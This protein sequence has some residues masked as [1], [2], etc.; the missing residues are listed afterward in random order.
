MVPDRVEAE[1]ALPTIRKLC[2]IVHGE[3]RP[4]R[5]L[6][7]AAFNE[8]VLVFVAGRD[9]I[10]HFEETPLSRDISVLTR[11]YPAHFHRA[12]P[13]T[14][15]ELPDEERLKQHRQFV[16][17]ILELENTGDERFAGLRKALEQSASWSRGQELP[18][19][20][21]PLSGLDDRLMELGGM[22]RY[23]ECVSA[24]LPELRREIEERV[25]KEDKFLRDTVGMS[26]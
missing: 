11:F 20:R 10:P 12:A 7:A 17:S 21:C 15:P 25:E 23:Y 19:R 18:H 1:W 13:D 3:D 5:A 6:L 8:I 16:N 4:G 26:I 9:I 14:Q 24:L 22:L 2:A